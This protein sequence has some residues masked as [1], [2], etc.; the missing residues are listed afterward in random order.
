[1]QRLSPQ[2]IPRAL[3]KIA[4]KGFAKARILKYRLLSRGKFSGASPK[5]AQPVLLL[6]NGD[7]F[8]GKNVTFGFQRSPNFWDSYAFV[9]CRSAQAQIIFGHT[10]QI[11]NNFSVICEKTKIQIGD[12]CFV[13]HGVTI[14]DSDFHAVDPAARMCNAAPR[15]MPVE[16]GENVFIGSKCTILKGTVIGKNS[17]IGAGS[18]VSGTFPENSLIRGNPAVLIKKILVSCSEY[19]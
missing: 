4:R 17:V 8:L 16:I 5:C 9:D 14:F 19:Y 1:M 18:V 2:S 12:Y 13:G 7:V 11:N 6:N 10:I 3:L 15:A